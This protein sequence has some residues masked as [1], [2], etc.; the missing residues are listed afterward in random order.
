M[1]LKQIENAEPSEAAGRFGRVIEA[2]RTRGFAI[3][4]IYHL[5]AHRPKQARH[6]AAYMQEVMRGPSDLSPGQRELIAALTSA[7][8]DCLF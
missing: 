3:P 4:Q 2:G 6:L 5:F 1:F 7:E 8:N